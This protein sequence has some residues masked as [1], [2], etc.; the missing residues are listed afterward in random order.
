[1]NVKDFDFSLPKNNI[2]QKPN[3][4]RSDS[5]LLVINR[6]TSE[7]KDDKF[8]NIDEYI[9]END[10][11]IVND[12][13][14][15]PARLFGHREKTKGKVE[16]LVE[17]IINDESFICQIK[18]TR[19]L[20]KDDI[21]IVGNDIKLLIEKNNQILCEIKILDYS[22]NDL[23]INYGSIPLP[24]YISR[25]P[26]DI[27]KE[28]YQTIFADKNGSVAAP[29]AA[30][31][32]D[33]NILNKLIIKK[34]LICKITLHIGIGT[35]SPIKTQNIT[36]HKMHSEL[37]LIPEV[38]AKQIKMCRARRGKIFAVGTTVARALESFY[39]SKKNP[40]QFYETDIF[41]KPGYKF[42]SVDHLITN[43]HLPRS[44]LLVMVSAFY[45]TK[46]ILKAYDFAIDNNYKFFSYGDSTLIL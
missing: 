35:F 43:F 10:L 33:K 14:V 26:E 18:S 44:S 40:E 28:F 15:I 3:R 22:V 46:K 36:Q 30:L 29:T 6:E 39:S 9:T 4:K 13:K 2:A 1:M 41:I 20:K 16:I 11:L 37:Y 31:H 7:L 23:L 42:I 45:D 24:P 32:F 27:D 34:I 8:N 17:R 25:D 19:K 5:R 21:V 12:T 38:T